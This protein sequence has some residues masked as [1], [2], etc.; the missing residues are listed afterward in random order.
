MDEPGAAAWWVSFLTRLPRY[1]YLMRKRWWVPALTVSAGL[2]AA[3]WFLA[4][5]PAL[6]KSTARLIVGGKLVLPENATYFEEA[7]QF[8]N[9]QIEWMRSE[10]VQERAAERVLA[11]EP[12]IKPVPV[13]FD[14]E[15]IRNTTIFELTAIGSDPDYTRKYLRAVVD[16]YM[17]ARKEM[18]SEKSELVSSQLSGQLQQFDKEVRDSDD[19]LEAFEKQNSIGG[20]QQDSASTAAYLAKLEGQLADLKTEAK[21]L[22]LLNIDQTVEHNQKN[23]PAATD[24]NP[25]GIPGGDVVKNT[26]GSEVDYLKARQ[27]IELLKAKR[28]ELSK[29]LRPKHPDMIQLNQDIQR[30]ETLIGMFRSQ[31]LDQLKS[32]KESLALQIQNIQSS[33]DEWQA[34]AQVLNQKMAEY[35]RIKARES[36]AKANYDWIQTSARSV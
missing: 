4:T 2:L 15:I 5:Q 12:G 25:A 20:L 17:D 13:K 7:T 14:A 35:N 26:N 30:E 27:E 3:G 24:D 9:T 11:V 1:K 8:L 6:Y 21:L 10:D 32:H 22:D 33:I 19:E 18:R 16:E 28:D 36:R 31:T 34:K 23:K 29:V